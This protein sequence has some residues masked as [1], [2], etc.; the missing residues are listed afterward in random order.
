MPTGY[1]YK[2]EDVDGFTFREYAL[3]CMGAFCIESREGNFSS[4]N[5]P[6]EIVPQPYHNKEWEK[7]R[8]KLVDFQIAPKE[9]IYKKWQEA[10]VQR[11]KVHI[12]IETNR[13][14][15]FERYN[16][17]QIQVEAWKPP[18][19][20]HEN[21]KAFMLDQI[22]I[23]NIGNAEPWQDDFKIQPF[24]EWKQ[25]ELERLDNDIHYHMKE[26]EKEVKACK[27][28]SKWREELFKALPPKKDGDKN[29]ACAPLSEENYK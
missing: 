20:N 19:K 5:P 8:I 13:V 14:K 11:V 17:M 2:I 16:A 28:T 27:E 29:D 10:Q 24:E 1:T 23:S 3:E 15:L 7:N 12:R 25:E 9:I 18:T 26:H 4:E 21:Y 22:K 6:I